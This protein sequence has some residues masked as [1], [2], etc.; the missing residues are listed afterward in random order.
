MKST[1][2]S[3]GSLEG[4][5]FHYTVLGREYLARRHQPEVAQGALPSENAVTSTA[6]LPTP[7]ALDYRGIT[8]GG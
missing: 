6:T 7:L 8:V 2:L 3:T 5:M 1:N 4:L